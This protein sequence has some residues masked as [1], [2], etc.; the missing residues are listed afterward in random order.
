MAAAP[1]ARLGGVGGPLLGTS[2]LSLT[3]PA[4]SPHW[5]MPP[6]KTSAPPGMP[7]RGLPLHP[8]L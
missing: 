5:R 7:H 3:S 8:T 2:G 1:S 4:E 6:S